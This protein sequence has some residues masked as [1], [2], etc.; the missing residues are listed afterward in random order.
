MRY[1][2]TSAIVPLLVTEQRSPA[3]QAEFKRDPRIITW[4]ATEVECASAIARR[5]REAELDSTAVSTALRRLSELSSAWQEID[6]QPVVR[7]TAKRLLRVHPLRAGDALQ[8]AAAI[9]AASG[10]P[11]TLAVVTLDERLALAAE[12]EGF[13]IV[14]PVA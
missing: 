10:E 6:A 2:D 4:W 8:L 1:W 13:P 9:A 11:G 5:E 7:E 3:L 12:R 14:F